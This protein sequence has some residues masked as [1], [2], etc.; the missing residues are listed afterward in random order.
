MD[1]LV[2]TFGKEVPEDGAGKKVNGVMRDVVAEAEDFGK[3]DVK[4]GEHQERAQDGPKVA[5]N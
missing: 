5:Q 3:D 4:D 2:G 1:A